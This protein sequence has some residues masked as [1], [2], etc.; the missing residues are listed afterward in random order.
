MINVVGAVLIKENSIILGR[1]ASNLKIFQIYL[2]F[3][4]EK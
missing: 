4:E 2:N 1:R 3:P